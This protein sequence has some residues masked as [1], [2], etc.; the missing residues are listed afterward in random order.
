MTLTKHMYLHQLLSEAYTLVASQEQQNEEQEEAENRPSGTLRIV[1]VSDNARSPIAPRSA[2]VKSAA[3][4]AKYSG[5]G[6]N[7]IATKRRQ[8]SA[9]A[10]RRSTQFNQRLAKLEVSAS[11]WQ[12]VLQPKS[13]A[14]AKP[15]K[16]LP[17]RETHGKIAAAPSTAAPQRPRRRGSMECRPRFPR[18]QASI[19]EQILDNNGKIG[20]L[21]DSN[22]SQVAAN[23]A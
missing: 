15:T 19:V 7:S 18:R 1:L 17:R 20:E 14:S 9:A 8:S 2:A 6:R 11:R 4:R 10:K 5:K 23:A 12:S 3:G 22:H 21:D 16:Q 13:Q